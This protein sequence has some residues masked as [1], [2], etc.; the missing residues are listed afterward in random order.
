MMKCGKCKAIRYMLADYVNDG[1]SKTEQETV[2]S[3]LSQCAAC[4]K[5]LSEVQATLQLFAAKKQEI[6]AI[7]PSERLFSEVLA[8]VEEQSFPTEFQKTLSI[9]P[10]LQAKI[11]HVLL[12]WRL[13]PKW[14]VGVRLSPRVRFVAIACLA[15]AI[16][17][18]GVI[19]YKTVQD[20]TVNDVVLPASYVLDNVMS[21]PAGEPEHF[22][23]PDAGVVS[24]GVETFLLQQELIIAEQPEHLTF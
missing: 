10:K 18:A 16:L 20:R 5:E 15:V 14:L 11:A 9:L 17:G 4:R 7:R 1:L 19:V 22:I 3:H 12:C 6:A 23:L 2:E 21:T 13:L 24:K 8:N